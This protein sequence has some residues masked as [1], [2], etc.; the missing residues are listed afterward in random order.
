MDKNIDGI[1]NT[2][3]TLKKYNINQTGI[4]DDKEIK[5]LIVSQKNIKLGR[6]IKNNNV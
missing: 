6:N 1:K 4:S 3:G 2:V 5:P